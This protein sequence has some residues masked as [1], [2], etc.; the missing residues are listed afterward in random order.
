[1]LDLDRRVERWI[2]DH[3]IELLDPLVVGLTYAGSFGAL[4]IALGVVAGVALRRPAIAIGVPLTVLLADLAAAGVK[5]AV[6]RERPEPALGIDALV[7][8]PASPAFPSGHATT[9]FAAAVV[10][11]AAV[12]SL[13]PLFVALAALMAFS[14]LYVGVHYPLDVAG[15]AALGALLATALLLLARALP[16]WRLRPTP[17]PPT[18]RWRGRP[19]RRT[20]RGSTRS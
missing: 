11:A 17:D 5:H 16:R 7:D 2:A 10:L 14:R 12:P 18:G 19:S 6:E 3:R 1:M 4:W 15:G 20:R 9:S 8:T 13:A